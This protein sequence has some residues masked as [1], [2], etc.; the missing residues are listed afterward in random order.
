MVKDAAGLYGQ[1]KVS[2][3]LDWE[4][5]TL[6]D[7]HSCGRSFNPKIRINAYLSKSVWPRTGKVSPLPHYKLRLPGRPK[8]TRRRELYRDE[9]IKTA[10]K[11]AKNTPQ[12]FSKS[13]MGQ[14]KFKNC[15]MTSHNK[16]TC[17]VWSSSKS[18]KSP[19]QH[20]QMY[21]MQ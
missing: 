20:E 21:F 12:K 7:K 13:G 19:H 14:L 18:C 8:L 6:Q 9:H 10:K 1:K 16:R 17:G 3:T 2:D 4:I 11:I 5:R 15:G